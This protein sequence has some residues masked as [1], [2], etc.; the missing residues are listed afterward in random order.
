MMRAIIAVAAVLLTV[1]TQWG[2]PPASAAFGNELL[3]DRFLKLQKSD[4]PEPRILVIDIDETSTAELGPWP[5]PRTI[6]Q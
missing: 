6:F 1:W 3:R 4:T 5:W 2:P